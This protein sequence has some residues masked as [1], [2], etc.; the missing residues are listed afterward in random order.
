MSF[1]LVLIALDVDLNPVLDLSSGRLRKTLGVSR[2]RM[3]AETWWSVQ[4]RGEEALTQAIGR[5]A[6]ERGVVAMLAPSAA[7]NAATNMVIFPDNLHT[8]DRLVIVNADRL[9]AQD[10]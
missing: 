7:H 8:T 6:R 1:P 4:D 3:L 2:K 10:G 9:P 5:L